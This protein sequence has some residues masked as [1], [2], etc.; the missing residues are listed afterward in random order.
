MSE[1]IVYHGEV[2]GRY[3]F[4]EH[5]PFGPDRMDVF[6]N[7]F[8]E[9]GLHRHVQ[10]RLPCVATQEEIE[11][12]H[13]HDYV[14]L[15]KARSVNGEGYLD[16]GDTPAY[17]GVYDTAATVAGTVLDALHAIMACEAR[18]VFVPIAGLHHARRDSASGFC[19]FNDCGIA[20][21]TLLGEYALQRV[22]YV[23]IDAHH[24]DGV[25]YGFVDDPR[26]LFADI[27]EDGRFLYPGTGFVNETGT[28]AA[29]GMKLNCPVPP[30]SRDDVFD[31]HWDKVEAYLHR[32]RPEFI[33]LQAGADSIEGDP[34]TH[35]CFSTHAHTTATK[36][37]CEIADQYAKGRLLV[38]GGGGYNRENIAKTWSSVVRVMADH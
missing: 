1:T 6:V 17:V 22:A 9:L 26:V 37:L 19:V 25:F 20:I 23:D 14:E 15:V 10:E 13:T 12:F 11:R 38:T 35:M 18:R 5:H 24:G 8:R 7:R 33:I 28:G 32:H 29:K 34:I 31:I 3:G 27:H 30:H 21:E 2:L 16:G 4:G 36:R